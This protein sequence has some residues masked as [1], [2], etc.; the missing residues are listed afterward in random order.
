MRLGYCFCLESGGGFFVRTVFGRGGGSVE[1]GGGC[2]EFILFVG[3]GVT[4]IFVF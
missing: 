1:L 4:D 3:M 2:V